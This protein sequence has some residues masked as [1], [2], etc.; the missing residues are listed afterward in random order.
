MRVT[1]EAN[2]AFNFGEFKDGRAQQPLPPAFQDH[3]SEL[4]EFSDYCYNLCLKLLRL[5]GM[6]LK[7]GRR[8][9]VLRTS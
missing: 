5:F 6:A 3:E 2:R 9:T 8:Q 7:V 1:Y 4:N